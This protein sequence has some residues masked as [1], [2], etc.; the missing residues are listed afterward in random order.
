MPESTQLFQI[1]GSE[2]SR[3]NPGVVCDLVRLCRGGRRGGGVGGEGAESLVSPCLKAGSLIS[4]LGLRTG[5]RDRT[6]N[7]QSEQSKKS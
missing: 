3:P 2:A 6:L 4:E 1:P 5:V 7:R